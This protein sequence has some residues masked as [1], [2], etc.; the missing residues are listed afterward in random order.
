MRYASS[1]SLRAIATNLCKTH[2]EDTT[3]HGKLLPG[4]GK[5]CISP[6]PV[7]HVQPPEEVNNNNNNTNNNNNNN[8]K[9]KNNTNTNTNNNNNNNNKN[10]NNNNNNNKHLL[11]LV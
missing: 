3:V 4:C 1:S 2:R 11:A 5:G 8:N 10:N 6:F 7:Q 9:N